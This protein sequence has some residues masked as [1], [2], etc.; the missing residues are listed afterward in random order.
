MAKLPREFLETMP[1]PPISSDVDLTALDWMP[2]NVTKLFAS[3]T[4]AIASGDEFRAA[5]TLWCRAWHQIPAGSLPNDEKALA[6]LSGAGSKWKR[7]REVALR[8]FTLCSDGRLYHETICEEAERTWEKVKQRRERTK[9]AT[10]ARKNQRNGQRDDERNVE[11]DD[12]PKEQRNDER[13]AN[14]TLSEG[15]GQVTVSPL[16]SETGAGAPLG[17]ILAPQG[18][19][20]VPLF[21]QALQWLASIYNT[22]PDKLRSLVG[23]WKMLAGGNDKRVFDLIAAA[24]RDAIADPRA[25]VTA[26]LGGKNEPAGSQNGFAALV[27]AGGV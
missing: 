18:D 22:E 16:R 12:P 8:G 24:Q 7:L 9:A 10:D 2:L 20:S 15:Q 4:Y 26:Q 17:Q 14:V 5:V 3:D 21:R 27:A 23:R 1:A 13:K 6:G 11:R 25:W 19:W